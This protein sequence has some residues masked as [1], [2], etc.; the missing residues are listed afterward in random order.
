MEHNTYPMQMRPSPNPGRVLVNC[1]RCGGWIEFSAAG[2][3]DPV[4]GGVWE[5]LVRAAR[6]CERCRPP[7]PRSN[8][9]EARLT[10]AGFPSLYTHHRDTGRLFRAAPVPTAADWFWEH[11]RENLLVT[12][13]SGSGK[14]TSACFTAMRLMR[15]ELGFTVRYLTL[16]RLASMWRDAR[17]GD[18]PGADAALLART[19][20]NSVCIL[21][22][23]AI[24]PMS[25]ATRG[26]VGEILE[27][28]NSGQAR[29]RVWML[30]NFTRETF[31]EMLCDPVAERRRFRENF[32]AALIGEGGKCE[33]VSMR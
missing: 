17:T 13:V 27:A 3:D 8:D 2:R 18:R 12:G 19:L 9:M 25:E 22:E 30:G 20:D 29:G 16:G 31:G 7:A 4:M 1:E 26:L 11:R 21:D 23:C 6:V 24:T 10:E 14:T 5:A 15:A 33:R 28:V 32:T